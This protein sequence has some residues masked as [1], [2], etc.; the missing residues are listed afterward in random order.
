MGYSIQRAGYRVKTFFTAVFN[1][2]SK[3]FP[4]NFR[5][6]HMLQSLPVCLH[7]YVYVYFC[8]RLLAHDLYNDGNNVCESEKKKMPVN[9]KKRR[10]DKWCE[11]ETESRI[12]KEI[13]RMLNFDGFSPSCTLLPSPTPLH[14]SF[15]FLTLSARSFSVFTYYECINLVVYIFHF[16]SQNSN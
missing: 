16:A 13:Q 1:E 6:S 8:T 10:K 4:F 14:S 3:H 11:S 9:K 15:L 5:H 2:H 7:G 12:R